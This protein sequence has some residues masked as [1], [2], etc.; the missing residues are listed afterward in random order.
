MEIDKIYNEDCLIGMRNIPDKSIDWIPL[1]DGNDL[2]YICKEGF[3]KK[4]DWVEV[5]KNGKVRKKRGHICKKMV[6]NG[7]AYVYINGKMKNLSA[8]VLDTFSSNPF[9]FRYIRHK[10]GNILN[11]SISNLEWYSKET[12]ILEHS[13]NLS[14]KEYIAKYYEISRTGEVKRKKDGKVIKIVR[15]PKGYSIIR[16][17]VPAFSKN[18]DR[19]KPYKIHRLVAMF[20]L[21]DYSDSLQVNHKN[22]VKTDNRVENLEMVT[23]QQNAIHAW[24]FLD[25]TE[26]R[27][28]L[29]KRR[30]PNGEFGNNT[31]G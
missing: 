12:I 4:K 10:D 9:G 2:Y 20:Y 15:G 30:R 3:V 11:N 6:Q 22:G 1:K 8:L 18:K 5:C 7:L 23:N 16:L 13:T 14:E 26:R 25:S 27:K 28:K 24:R 17:K 21:E 19:R 31:R 29:E